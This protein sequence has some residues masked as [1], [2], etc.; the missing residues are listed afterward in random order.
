MSRTPAGKKCL[1]EIED[2]KSKNQK[3]DTTQ[4]SALA[5]QVL[6][7]EN[8]G[9]NIQVKITPERFGQLAEEI[10]LT[11]NED[12][13]IYY[14]PAVKATEYSKA[15]PPLGKLYNQYSYKNTS[16]AQKRKDKG[17][18]APVN[19]LGGKKLQIAL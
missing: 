9:F 19:S 5:K 11:F 15:S 17:L 18:P 2:C 10:A 14:L 8:E 12:P 16:R 3:I 6:Q 13:S 4:R 7:R 1:D